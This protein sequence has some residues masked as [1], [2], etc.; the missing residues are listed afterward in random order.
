MV[1]PVKFLSKS[2]SSFLIRYVKKRL[3]ENFIKL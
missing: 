3:F 1:D 2:K